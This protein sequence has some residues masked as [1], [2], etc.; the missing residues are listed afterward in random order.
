MG[1]DRGFSMKCSTN[2]RAKEGGIDGKCGRSLWRSDLH[3][4]KKS[5]IMNPKEMLWP[6]GRD[7]GDKNIGEDLSLEIEHEPRSIVKR[8]E[9]RHR[10]AYR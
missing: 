7:C 2:P 8:T 4:H 5:C 9:R 10:H 1:R 6:K 3:S